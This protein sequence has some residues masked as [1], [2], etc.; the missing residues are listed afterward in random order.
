MKKMLLAVVALAAVA[1]N[2]P[3]PLIGT[4]SG[5]LDFDPKTAMSAMTE[6]G[7]AE[8]GQQMVDASKDIADMHQKIEL[9]ADHTFYMGDPDKK[10]LGLTGTWKHEGDSVFLT[11][12]AGTMDG[13]PLT[14][15]LAKAFIKP[16]TLRVDGAS[17][18]IGKPGV[19][20]K[21]MRV[22]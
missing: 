6:K 17:L 14:G 21:F 15:N 16:S 3:D 22:Y 13:K 2:R 18:V 4:Y 19:G 20:M 9:K 11:P 1:C 8:E 5:T 12:T 10:F 7:R